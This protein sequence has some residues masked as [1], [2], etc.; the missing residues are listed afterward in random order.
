MICAACET[1]PRQCLCKFVTFND[2]VVFPSGSSQQTDLGSSKGGWMCVLT[3]VC[4]GVSVSMCA[5]LYNFQFFL[6]SQRLAD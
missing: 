6:L 2:S 1:F 3:C 4:V 5:L